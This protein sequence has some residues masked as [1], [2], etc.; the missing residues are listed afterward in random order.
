MS[1]SQLEEDSL[2]T[3]NKPSAP[4]HLAK[5]FLLGLPSPL[6]C[7]KRHLMEGKAQFE[8]GGSLERV[9]KGKHTPLYHLF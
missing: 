4:P 2:E 3:K 6:D 9:P 8:G 1:S 5:L 7:M